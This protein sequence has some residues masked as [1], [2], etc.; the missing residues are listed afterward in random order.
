MNRTTQQG[1]FS[2]RWLVALLCVG[3]LIA[4]FVQWRVI[5]ELRRQNDSLRA[6]QRQ[7]AA[8]TRDTTVPSTIATA[9]LEQL[10][11]DQRELMRLRNEVRQLREQVTALK[12]T[13]TGGGAEKPAAALDQAQSRADAIRQLGVA[14]S[15]GD[16]SA[17]D[18]LAELSDA[19]HAQ[20]KTNHDASVFAELRPAFEV[21][22][23]EAG[24]GSDTALQA[25]W[26]AMRMNS[27]QGFAIDALGAAAGQGNDKALEPLLEPD[28]YLILRSSAVGALKPAADSGNVRAIQA[29]A[30]VAFEPD[31]KPLWFLAAEGLRKA[32]SSGNVAAIDALT[33]LMRSDNDN[34]R[35]EAIAGLEAAAFNQSSRAQEAL[36][37]PSGK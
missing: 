34:A 1:S 9:E 15:T 21:L 28:R 10:R 16:F 11:K 20:F 32:A 7:L 26:K 31:A 23:A 18:K 22:G 17:L 30:A 29:L 24:K 13:R 19:A 8:V 6:E 37:N 25:L 36:R 12:T 27:V 4:L 14:A 5:S 35:R 33:E 2:F 3:A